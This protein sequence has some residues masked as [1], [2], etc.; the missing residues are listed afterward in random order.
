MSISE[1]KKKKISD[2]S[3]APKTG[4]PGIKMYIASGITSLGLLGVL[5]RRKKNEKDS[6][7]KEDDDN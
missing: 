5:H 1:V 2:K 6:E 3:R 7:N 4:D